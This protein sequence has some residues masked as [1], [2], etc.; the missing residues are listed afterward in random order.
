[1]LDEGLEKPAPFQR[2]QDKDPVKAGRCKLSGRTIPES[3]MWPKVRRSSA[4]NGL[5]RPEPGSCPREFHR[6][7]LSPCC[8]WQSK[9]LHGL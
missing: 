8:H 9:V 7:C 3:G 5:L 4:V 6:L 1:M 2:S